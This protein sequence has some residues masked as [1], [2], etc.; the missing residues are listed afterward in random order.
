MHV[1][2]REREWRKKT[3]SPQDQKMKY[4]ELGLIC[5]FDDIPY[6]ISVYEKYYRFYH[7]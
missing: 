3:F 4:F 7:I 5:Y 6:N 1:R 2:E